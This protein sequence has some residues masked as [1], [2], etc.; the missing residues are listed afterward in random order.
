MLDW[1]H[2]NLL[3]PRK[4]HAHAY[5]DSGHNSRLPH[6]DT[7]QCQGLQG[8]ILN[9]ERMNCCSLR[10]PFAFCT[11]SAFCGLIMQISFRWWWYSFRSN[12]NGSLS[13]NTALA[14]NV[15]FR[16]SGCCELQMECVQRH[17]V[18]ASS[19]RTQPE[20]PSH[21]KRTRKGT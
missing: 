18:C 7:V 11:K 21:Q 2:R 13:S 1:P 16:L 9:S 17:S 15:L 19:Y 14:V 6:V 4:H 20:S 5:R 10:S 3:G 8:H 12:T